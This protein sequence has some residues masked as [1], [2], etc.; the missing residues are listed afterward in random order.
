LARPAGVRDWVNVRHTEDQLAARLSIARDTVVATPADE[1]DP[2]ELV[3]YLRD[4]TT[5]REIL[6]GWCSA[7]VSPR[8]QG[9]IGVVSR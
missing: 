8:P 9:C 4:S 1:P 6:N 3:G 5:A 7:F 2:H